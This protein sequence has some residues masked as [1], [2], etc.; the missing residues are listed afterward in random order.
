M[1]HWV[2]Y[3]GDGKM[4]SSSC[5]FPHFPPTASDLINMQKMLKDK[6]EL[7]ECIIL[8]WKRLTEE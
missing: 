1:N 7:S 2:L 8:D 6:F 3:M 4:G 5:C